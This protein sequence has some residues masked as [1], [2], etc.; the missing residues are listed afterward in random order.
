MNL[1]C[2]SPI[3]YTNF[4]WAVK[5]FCSATACS[6]GF[7]WF[8][9]DR[10][11]GEAFRLINCPHRVGERQEEGEG[12]AKC[13]HVYPLSEDPLLRA[14]SL[15]SL[16]LSSSTYT[17]SFVTDLQVITCCCSEQLQVQWLKGTSGW[18]RRQRSP[19]LCRGLFSNWAIAKEYCIHQ[20]F[21]NELVFR[22]PARR[23]AKTATLLGV[24]VHGQRGCL[25]LQWLHVCVSNGAEKQQWTPGCLRGHIQRH[26]TEI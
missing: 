17:L 18:W 3:Q 23:W 6:R 10:C 20:Q 8:S 7:I 4:Q 19:A 24:W 5:R 13:S 14:H 22:K 12:I 25:L 26:K 9:A 2:S 15:S 1:R 16:A 11:R 21:R